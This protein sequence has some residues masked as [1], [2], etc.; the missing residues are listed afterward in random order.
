MVKKGVIDF[1]KGNLRI[2]IP[3]IFGNGVLCVS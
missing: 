2:K 1:I 3:L